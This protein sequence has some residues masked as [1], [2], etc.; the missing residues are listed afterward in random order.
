MSAVLQRSH[1]QAG[2]ILFLLIFCAQLWLLR[3]VDWADQSLWQARL[4][5]HLGDL[6]EGGFDPENS[7]VLYSNHP[8]L[9]YLTPAVFLLKAGTSSLLALRVTMA[10]LVAFCAAL[11]VV[12]VAKHFS[13]HWWL[14]LIPTLGFNNLA[15]GVTPTS[16]A[17]IATLPALVVLTVLLR[18]KATTGLVFAWSLVAVL[19][20]MSRWPVSVVFIF[21]LLPLFVLQL[22]RKQVFVMLGTWIVGFVVFNPFFLTQAWRQIKYFV[23]IALRQYDAA[24]VETAFRPSS[25][26]AKAGISIISL[27]VG[28]FVSRG[29]QLRDVRAIFFSMILITICLAFLYKTMTGET[30][31]HWFPLF[32]AWQAL[33]PFWLLKIQ[34]KARLL[35]GVALL[36][37]FGQITL[38]FLWL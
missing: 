24:V 33:L 4:V 28:F 13:W 19:A 16:A 31:R 3:Q 36:L 15:L 35:Q 1:F 38:T 12:L 18:K 29:R 32:V 34:I 14:P 23:L 8:G 27:V 6:Q 5:Q 11:S 22:S 26:L 10:F 20:F 9:S 7:D 30:A 37:F 25:F 17:A 21:F 2:I